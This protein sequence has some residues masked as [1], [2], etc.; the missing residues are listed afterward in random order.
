MDPRDVGSWDLD[1]RSPDS[2]DE[3]QKS[4]INTSHHMRFSAGKPLLLLQQFF[5]IDSFSGTQLLQKRLYFVRF[6]IVVHKKIPNK[7]E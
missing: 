4:A 2:C 7:S 6:E 3:V 1:S 5:T